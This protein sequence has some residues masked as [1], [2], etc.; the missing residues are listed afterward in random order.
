MIPWNELALIWA[1]S[2]LAMTLVWALCWRVSNAGYVDVAW[3]ALM[4]AAALFAGATGSGAELPR[5]LVALMGSIWGARLS[6]HVLHRVLHEP[7]DG[8]YRYLR[9]HWNGSQLKFFL[10][11]Q[12]QAIFVVLFALPMLIAA[13]NPVAG[14]SL[15]TV[16]AVAIW[17]I[18]VVGESMADA[19]LTRFRQNPANRGK[20]CRDGLW[21]W[22]RHPNY[23]FEWLHWFSYV[24]LAIGAPHGWLALSGP[25]LMLL[26]LYRFTGIPY[27]EAQALRSRGDDYRAYQREVSALIPW[28]PKS[29]NP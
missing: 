28:P 1:A 27:T 26:F 4:A 23:F 11:F 12:G 14:V 9:E 29:S 19:Q 3:A 8:R 25:L 22:S 17:L 10:F 20:T 15:W 21:G 13:R 2:A 7:E 24:L 16:L 18:S 6:L 5:L